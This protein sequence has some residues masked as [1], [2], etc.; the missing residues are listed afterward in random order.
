MELLSYNIGI[1]K[2]E[3]V[4][5]SVFKLLNIEYDRL[6]KRTTINEILIESR[7]LAHIQLAEALTTT[8]NNTLHSDGTSKFGHKYQSYQVATEEGSLT[9]GL[10]VS[11][12]TTCVSLESSI[13]SI[14]FRKS[15]Q[16]HLRQR[17]MCYKMSLKNYLKQH[18]K[19]VSAI[20]LTQLL[21][22]LKV[23]C[24]TG[25]QHKSH[26]TLYFRILVTEMIFFLMLYK[27]GIVCQ[28]TSKQQ[29]PKC[30]TFIAVCTW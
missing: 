11:H 14:S 26:S 30:T 21:P 28:M 24:R 16:E 1:L 17:Y 25:L 23:Q 18:R 10:Q 4:L 20:Q 9:L 22:T 5:Q 15:H 2:I 13:N 12:C 3:P 8:T 6:P 7:S 27:I 19:P 29:Y